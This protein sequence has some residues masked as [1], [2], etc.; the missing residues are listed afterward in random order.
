MSFIALFSVGVFLAFQFIYLL[1]LP[2]PD[3]IKVSVTLFTLVPLAIY[4]M[5][6]KFS[7]GRSYGLPASPSAAYTNSTRRL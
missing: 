5:C 7:C 6:H 1:Q 4:S 3:F 2:F